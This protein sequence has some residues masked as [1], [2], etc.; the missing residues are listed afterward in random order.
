[1]IDMNTL[2]E[3]LCSE[4]EL[5][6]RTN[7]PFTVSDLEKA[8]LL[9]GTIKNILRI[10]QMCCDEDDTAAET[11]NYSPTY[12]GSG[13]MGYLRYERSGVENQLRDML[14]DPRYTP[15]EKEKLRRMIREF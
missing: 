5:M 13:K 2:K 6:E 8:N 4:V 15:S 12:T 11:N 10:E 14:D 1:M 9:T 7:S 3:R